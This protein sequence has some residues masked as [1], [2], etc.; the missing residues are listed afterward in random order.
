MI[1]LTIISVGK[2]HSPVF[3]DAI[4]MYE[5]RLRPYCKLSWEFIPSTNIDDEG[6]RILH[7][8]NSAY[9]I[10]LDQS[11]EHYSTEA[12]VGMLEGFQNRAITNIV[13]VIGG[14]YGVSKD[15]KV[16]AD[17]LIS[18]GACTFPHQL[19]RVLIV[20]Q[21][22]RAYSVLAGSAYHHT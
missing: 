1:N 4:T 17:E 21:L 7:R 22:Y 14:S 8:S 20:E 10:V 9:A 15:V 2:K 16:A 13:I 12:F 18:L 6:K 5:K 3:V 19:M 11:G